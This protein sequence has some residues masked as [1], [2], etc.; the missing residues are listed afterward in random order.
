MSLCNVV[1][2]TT[3]LAASFAPQFFTADFGRIFVT[4]SVLLI[5]LFPAT[6]HHT[7]LGQS[8]VVTGAGISS[9]STTLLT[10][11]IIDVGPNDSVKYGPIRCIGAT[12]TDGNHAVITFL[13]N[14]PTLPYISASAP[15]P[16]Q[17]AESFGMICVIRDD[18]SLLWFQTI[19][20]CCQRSEEL[21]SVRCQCDL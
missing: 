1:I 6:H 2:P 21:V 10:C 9:V 8:I 13:S 11:F 3:T 4:A 18:H 15:Q 16:V 5:E 14:P 7:V 17:L 19:E 20:S 12:L